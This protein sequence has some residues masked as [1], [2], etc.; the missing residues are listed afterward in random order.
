MKTYRNKVIIYLMIAILPS[1]AGTA[2]FGHYT[3]KKQ[4]KKAEAHAEWIATI[5]Q[6]QLGGLF[7]ETKIRLETLSMTFSESA[8]SRESL[9]VVLNN[10]QEKDS[11]YAGLY[12]ADS[13]GVIKYGSNNHLINKSLRGNETF[14]LAHLTGKTSISDKAE[15]NNQSMPVFSIITPI[16]SGDDIKGYLIGHIR[17]DYVVNLISMLTPGETIK[18]MNSNQEVILK[19]GPALEESSQQWVSDEISTAPW[20]ISVAVNNEFKNEAFISTLF[21]FLISEF[22]MH[23]IFLLFRNYRIGKRSRLEKIENDAQKLELVGTLAASTAHEIRNPLTG[24]KGLIQLLAEKYDNSQDQFY[25]SIINKEV[26][27]INQ[28]VSEFLILGKP[29]IHTA[30]N[31]DLR[32]ILLDLNPIIRSEANLKTIEYYYEMEVSPIEVYC[33]KDQIKQVIMNVSKNAF[34]SMMDGGTLTIKLYIQN[35]TGYI[36]IMDTGSG[37]SDE[38]LQRIFNP[39]FTSKDGGTG[40][41]LAVCKRIV[42]S[43][44]GSIEV[45]SELGKGTKVTIGFP[46]TKKEVRL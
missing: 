2:V 29:S 15:S 33:S 5:H 40:L 36:D 3:Y 16:V 37:I 8:P 10:L 43:F 42:Q 35:M 22:I 31:C 34:E 25:F 11:R 14:T 28:I 41:G 30:E 26:L 1:L 32:D 45:S 17:A 46:I 21:F 13:D 23:I 44:N 39:F 12:Y 38:D 6:H 7:H 27:R 19:A 20:I 24:I 9:N 18:F 4:F